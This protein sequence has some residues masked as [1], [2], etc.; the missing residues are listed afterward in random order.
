[1]FDTEIETEWWTIL[2]TP[3]TLKLNLSLTSGDIANFFYSVCTREQDLKVWLGPNNGAT[4]AGPK[5][6]EL[7]DLGD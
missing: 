6:A 4:N 5:V 3:T 2:V 7:F 1:M